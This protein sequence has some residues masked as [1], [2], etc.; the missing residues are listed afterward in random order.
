MK[1][2]K[3]GVGQIKC[4]DGNQRAGFTLIELLVVIAIIAI[5]IALL[6]PAVQ[7][8]RE[9][10]RRTQCTN[11]LKQIALAMHNFADARGHLPQGAR[12]HN[13]GA[14]SDPLND[15]SPQCCNSLTVAGWSWSYHLLPY[16]EQPSIFNLADPTAT[17]ASSTYGA[18]NLAVAQS[19]VPA[20]T[21][22]TRRAPT[23][24]GTNKIFKVDYA[25]NAGER[26]FTGS[27]VYTDATATSAPKGNLRAPASSG[28]KTGVIVQTD[29]SKVIIERITDGSSNTIMVAEKAIGLTGQ[30]SDGGENENWN[31]AGWDEDVVRHGAGRNGSGTTFGIPPLP[32]IKA[33]SKDWYN[34]FGGPHSG[35]VISAMGD[36]SV[37][38][39]NY[40]IDSNVFRR[41]SHRADAEPVGEF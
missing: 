15:T 25:G 38:G 30:G 34:N 37:R 24:Y 29:R 20:Y 10:A 41:L 11:N 17:S 4:G 14:P 13:S 40:N 8:A 1:S 22:P 7:Q 18:Q 16:M 36:G 28:E 9:A 31:N 39:I 32:D 23:A 5:L 3:C 2:R 21:C 6:L 26:E 12:D 35:V 19:K 33:P 27:A